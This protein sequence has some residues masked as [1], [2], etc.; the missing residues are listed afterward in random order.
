MADVTYTV[1]VEYLTKGNLLSGLNNAASGVKQTVNNLNQTLNQS[2]SQSLSQRISQSFSQSFSQNFRQT[3]INRAAPEVQRAGSEFGNILSAN[4]L[5]SMTTGAIT[6]GVD[7]FFKMAKVGLVEMNGEVEQLKITM[8]SMFAGSGQAQDFSQGFRAAGKLMS[9]MRKDAR[10]LPGEFK[11]LAQIMMRIATPAANAGLSIAETEKLAANAM[12]IGVGGGMHADVVGRELGELIRGNMSKRMPLLTHMPGFDMD[13]KEYNAMENSKRLRRLS[14]AM[15]MIAGTRE[16]EAVTQMRAAF[17]KSWT[18]L[19][20]TL[21]D[22]AKQTLGSLTESLFDRMKAALIK[23]NDWFFANQEKITEWA[24]RVGGFLADGFDRAMKIVERMIPFVE[25]MSEKLSNRQRDSTLQRDVGTV[26]GILAA[27]NLMATVGKLGVGESVAG[28]MAGGS[29]LGAA[30]AGIDAALAAVLTPAAAVLLGIGTVVFGVIEGLNNS[31][32]PLYDSF[33]IIWDYIGST[34]T[35]LFDSLKNTFLMLWPIFKRFAELLGMGVLVAVVGLAKALEGLAMVMETLVTQVTSALGSIRDKLRELFPGDFLAFL[36][37][38]KKPNTRNPISFHR[39][40]TDE[41]LAAM[42]AA[43]KPPNHTTHIHKV[44]IKVNSN[45]DPNRIAKK[46]FEIIE[47]VG[48]NPKTSSN[49]GNPRLS[50]G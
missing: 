1:E 12:A 31:L 48:R 4:M 25:K 9:I 36:D 5:A 33:Q 11:D 7:G 42:K 15:G 8:A 50:R 47:D 13:S 17:E 40:P 41:D 6:A 2:L 29:V 21:K 38:D 46:V 43:S 19:W 23:F 37:P 35:S 49:S 14:Q 10:E 34:L 20:S 27:G 22:Q 18:G 44:E 3:I 39:G 26:G 30:G 45:Q 16:A 32:G 28:A 24:Q